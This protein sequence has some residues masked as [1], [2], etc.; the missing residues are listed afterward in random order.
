MRE[1]RT[2]GSEGGAAQSN[3]P[4]LPLSREARLEER[5]QRLKE[6]ANLVPPFLSAKTREKPQKKLVDFR[7]NNLYV[8]RS[9]PFKSGVKPPH[10][11][12]ASS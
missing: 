5:Q 3:A 12:T 9:A 11:K 6:V 1:N 2:Y 8:S 4:F 10:S 7:R